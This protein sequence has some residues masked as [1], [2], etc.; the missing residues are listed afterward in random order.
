MTDIPLNIDHSISDMRNTRL[1]DAAAAVLADVRAN[2]PD[3]ELSS[4]FMQELASALSD[5]QHATEGT[6]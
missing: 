5:I 1:R 3:E 4:P 6:P 2:H